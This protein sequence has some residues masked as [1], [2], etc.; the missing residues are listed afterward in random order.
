MNDFQ[1]CS[2]NGKSSGGFSRIVAQSSTKSRDGPSAL[3]CVNSLRILRLDSIFR[4]SLL[5]TFDSQKCSLPA[6]QRREPLE[7][8][9]PLPA[10]PL[11]KISGES[12]HLEHGRRV[13]GDGA[14]RM[15][16]PHALARMRS[17]P[18]SRNR[19]L[20]RFDKSYIRDA[21]LFV[22]RTLTATKSSTI[23]S[24]SAIFRCERPSTMRV[25][26]RRSGSELAAGKRFT[27]GTG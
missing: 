26:A 24:R 1:N 10:K 9:G 25:V 12:R 16:V 14:G 5:T 6:Y 7:N 2:I 22:L 11:D 20:S 19:P 4:S 17:M 13:C 15:G 18:F 21:L 3:P 27:P 8:K 23:P